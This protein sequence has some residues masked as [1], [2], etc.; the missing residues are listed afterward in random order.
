MVPTDYEV[1][2]DG[3]VVL[4]DDRVTI[5]EEQATSPE[6]MEASDRVIQYMRESGQLE[7]L[8]SA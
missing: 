7:A 4:A 3:M 2:R 1:T 6:L 8:L 5:T